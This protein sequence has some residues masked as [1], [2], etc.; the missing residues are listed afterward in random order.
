MRQLVANTGYGGALGSNAKAIVWQT[1]RRLSGL[2]LPSL[3]TFSIPLPT[4][5]V[6][7]P[8]SPPLDLPVNALVLTS[9]AL[10][11][12][13]GYDGTFWRTASPTALPLNLTRPRVTASNPLGT[14]T[15]STAQPGVR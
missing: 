8:A 2:F 9:R 3:Q 5:I 7:A 4:A 14:T 11:V 12:E 13:D 6:K 10:Y 1:G 15:A